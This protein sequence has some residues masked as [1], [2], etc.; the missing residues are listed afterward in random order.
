MRG[1]EGQGAAWGFCGG[2]RS[3]VQVVSC[4]RGRRAEVS[5]H[6]RQQ[7]THLPVC[8]DTVAD[9]EYAPACAGAHGRLELGTHGTSRVGTSSGRFQARGARGPAQEENGWQGGAV[10]SWSGCIGQQRAGGRR[11]ASGGPG[12]E[13]WAGGGLQRSKQGRHS[14]V[15]S[16][17]ATDGALV[18]DA[19]THAAALPAAD[20]RPEPA[21]CGRL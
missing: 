12:G 11:A 19:V 3:G 14:L 16:Y 15:V 18:D 13:A 21:C 5:G 7:R 2:A 20:A 8:S 4:G 1:E 9:P 10:A 6:S 17:I